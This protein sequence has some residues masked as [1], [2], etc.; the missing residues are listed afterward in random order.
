MKKAGRWMIEANTQ[1]ATVAGKPS[2]FMGS[3]Q[4]TVALIG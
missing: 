1:K 4:L 3:V 2:N